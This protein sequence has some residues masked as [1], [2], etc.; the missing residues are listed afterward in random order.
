M[1]RIPSILRASGLALGLLAATVGQPAA[2]RSFEASYTGASSC[3]GEDLNQDGNPSGR[4]LFWGKSSLGALTLQAINDLDLATLL[5]P[6]DH[7]EAEADFRIFFFGAS[8]VFRFNDGSMLFKEMATDG[9][10]SFVCV[11]VQAGAA[12]STQISWD[13]VGGTGRFEGA[14]G[15]TVARGV[16]ITPL[17]GQNVLEIRESGEIST[18]R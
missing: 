13:V 12:T 3:C 7:C 15:T 1:M 17:T 10:E 9:R 18:P 5:P 8:A 11:D 16:A 6:L 4:G 2:A 14:S